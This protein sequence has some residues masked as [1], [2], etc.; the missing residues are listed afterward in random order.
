MKLE[1][2]TVYKN[3]LIQCHIDTHNNFV[4]SI[5]GVVIGRLDDREPVAFPILPVFLWTGKYDKGGDA[6]YCDHIVKTGLFQL[7][8]TV[9]PCLD[10]GSS[11]GEN[12]YQP[13]GSELCTPADLEIVHH[14]K[15]N[16]SV[17]GK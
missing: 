7:N 15:I 16:Q 11:F 9:V 2:A 5:C 3:Q 14:A 17:E 12:R 8:A 6:I 4:K 13:V 10:F 1:F